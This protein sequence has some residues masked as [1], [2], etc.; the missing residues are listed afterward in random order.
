MKWK[1]KRDF[2]W[3]FKGKEAVAG[4][5]TAFVEHRSASGLSAFVGR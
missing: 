2:M 4:M 1:Y 3:Q 5:G